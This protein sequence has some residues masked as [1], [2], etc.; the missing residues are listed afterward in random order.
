MLKAIITMLLC[1]VTAI[2]YAQPKGFTAVKDVAQFSTT[3]TR[4]NAGR[5]TIISDFSQVKNL[6]LLADK[7][8]SKGKFSFKKE[9]KVRIEYT[10]PY[11]YLIIMNGGQILIKDE[12]K[13]SK[14]N[15]RSSKT[16]QSVNRI[17]IDCM[18]GTVFSQQD[19]KVAAY[20]NAGNYLLTLIPA[21]EGLR[22]IFKQ[23]DVYLDKKTFDV[24]RLTMTEQGGDYTDMTFTNTKHNIPLSDALFK[25]K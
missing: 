9:D 2:V 8:K 13:T 14:V 7:I 15:T 3:L 12:Q 5:Q 17:M 25:V 16:L 10:S 21:N 22:K 24:D 6:T 1:C 4:A 18:R 11:S 19:F 23:I 20:E